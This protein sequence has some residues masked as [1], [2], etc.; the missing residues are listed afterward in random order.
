MTHADTGTIQH[1]PAG[2]CFLLA[3]SAINAFDRAFERETLWDVSN[4]VFDR[5]FPAA[6]ATVSTAHLSKTKA[7]DQNTGCR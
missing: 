6:P 1:S 5:Y 4:R 2:G 3:A 7:A